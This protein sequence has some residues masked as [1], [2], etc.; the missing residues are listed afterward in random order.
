MGY[1]LNNAKNLRKK[2]TNTENRIWFLLRAKRVAGFKFR[3]Q[4]PIGPYIVDFVC[5]QNRLIIEMDGTQHEEQKEK[6][7]KR[8]E[9][10]TKE[11]FRV[12]RFQNHEFFEYPEKTLKK[13]ALMCVS[14]PLPQSLPPRGGGTFLRKPKIQPQKL[15][16]K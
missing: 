15:P 2:S 10:L 3:R 14:H 13:I 6:D 8:D 12:L 7:M 5:L 11:G 9:W 4:H 16:L 1:L